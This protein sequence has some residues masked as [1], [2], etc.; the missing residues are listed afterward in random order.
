MS[1][2]KPEVGDVWEYKNGIKFTIIRQLEPLPDLFDNKNELRYEVIEDC[3]EFNL[4]YELAFYSGYY[5]Y[6]GKSKAKFEDLFKM[7]NE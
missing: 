1:K 5:T 7:E 2:D 3:E 4:L 6:L